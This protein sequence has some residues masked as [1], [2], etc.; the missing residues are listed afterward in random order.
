MNPRIRWTL[1]NCKKEALLYITRNEFKKKSPG[2][3]TRACRMGWLIEICAHM[4]FVY[5]K[6]S[7]E[8][9]MIETLK[10]KTKRE[11][12]EL[13][14]RLYDM[15]KKNRWLED[16][17]SHMTFEKKVNGYWNYEKCKEE[18]LKYNTKKEFKANSGTAYKTAY[19]NG[20]MGDIGSHMVS[21]G[22]KYKRLVYIFIFSDKAVYIGLTNDTTVRHNAHL[23]NKKSPVF[24]HMVS[25]HLTPEYLLLSDYIE[26]GEAARLEASVIIE[27][28]EKG[29][30]ILNTKKGGELGSSKLYWDY[31]RC[32]EE[33]SKFESRN[34]FRKLS[35]SAYTSAIKRGWLDDFFSKKRVYKNRAS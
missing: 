20:W 34:D 11:F 27:Y 8:N 24:K 19:A 17:T 2:A 30:T 22:H 9:A 14:H 12:R 26:V 21:L 10:Y 28:R 3:Y 15:C 5:G 25:T 18:A 33:A 32:K 16:A 6:I 7:K 1:E 13:D 31:E 29:Y 23:S 4:V 35:S